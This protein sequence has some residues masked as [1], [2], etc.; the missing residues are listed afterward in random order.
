LLAAQALSQ[1]ESP[2]DRR[3]TVRGQWA[4]AIALTDERSY[5]AAHP[6]Y[7]AAL[8][9]TPE[10]SDQWFVPFCLIGFAEIAVH[11]RNARQA[12]RVLAARSV[13]EG[14]ESAPC[15][16]LLVA[17]ISTAARST[18]DD[19]AWNIARAAVRRMMQNE[20][21]EEARAVGPPS[22]SRTG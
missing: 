22:V 2:G 20:A 14:G 5:G 7:Q 3:G 9:T 12:I 6:L 15:L 13:L 11:N 21:A 17:R 19:S 4:L 16:R 1:L 8:A 10:I 18:L